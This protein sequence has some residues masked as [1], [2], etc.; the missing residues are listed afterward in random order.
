MSRREDRGGRLFRMLT[1]LTG[2]AWDLDPVRVSESPV[3]DGSRPE[4]LPPTMPSLSAAVPRGPKG[5]LWLLGADGGWVTPP[6]DGRPVTFGR[7]AAEMNVCIGAGDDQ[8]SRCHGRLLHYGSEWWIRNEGRWPIQM[9]DSRLP[10][11]AEQERP[12]ST[13]Y[14]QLT[15]DTR[16]RE[17]RL[18][19]YVSGGSD[20]PPHSTVGEDDNPT[21]AGSVWTISI[22]QR[23]VVT[24]LAQRYL[25]SGDGYPQPL[26]WH[27]VAQELNELSDASDWNERKAA[28]VIE[29][30]RKDLE[31]QG[32]DG[33]P[34]DL[35]QPIGNAINDSI[36]QELLNSATVTPRDL[37]LLGIADG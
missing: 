6:A 32:W 28:R 24:V 29:G 9:S 33:P 22:R 18:E 26:P 4:F 7:N 23:M 34:K 14:T 1:T 13:G 30:L 27:A 21:A 8:V 20:E 15:I 2:E 11:L 10:M 31:A 12:M 5:T 19:V 36:I 37:A 16:R 35:P 17:H 25:E 3:P